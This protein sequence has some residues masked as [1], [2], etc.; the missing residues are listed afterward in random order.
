MQN[1]YIPTGMNSVCSP[2]APK[3]RPREFDID[4]AL[5]QA[6]LVFWRNGYEAASM[7]EL[8]SAMGITK[9]S[10]YAAFGNK[11]QLFHK[12][13]DLYEREK[14]AYMTSALEAPTAR[15][16]AERLLRGSL[17]MQM[18]TCDPKGCLGVI[19]AATCGAEAEPI[20]AEVV[21]RRA[22]S[23]AALVK[24]FA[25]AQA[26]GEFPEGMTPEALTRFL[27]AILQGLALQ[28]GSGATCA[29]L[30]QLVETSMA[31]WPTQ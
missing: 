4:E 13:L 7:T 25:E 8:T 14:L 5:G 3:G 10:L 26:A 23:E 2:S 30:S 31:V 21:K 20:K 9:P 18:S 19:S 11:E 28:G 15:G 6:L 27:F 22:S 16:V 12:A 1:A 24:R 29:E 17:E